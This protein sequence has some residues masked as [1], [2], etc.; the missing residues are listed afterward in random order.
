MEEARPRSKA[1]KRREKKR[2]KSAV[3]EE[4]EKH[5][6]SEL[7]VLESQSVEDI[8][9]TEPGDSSVVEVENSR[10]PLARSDSE[11]TSILV[12]GDEAT[13]QTQEDTA[14]DN[15]EDVSSMAELD[16]VRR[17]P[18]LT[19]L[20]SAEQEEPTAADDVSVIH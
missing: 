6:E 2:E 12:V 15:V 10:K 14:P 19:R 7:S 16:Q 20:E 4:P 18:S 5:E 8:K 3:S 9:A 17:E 11:L 1:R 13:Q